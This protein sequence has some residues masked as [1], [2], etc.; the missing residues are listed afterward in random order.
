MLSHAVNAMKV[1]LDE[2]KLEQLQ[3]LYKQAHDL[4]YG[5]KIK[6]FS[7]GFDEKLSLIKHFVDNYESIALNQHHQ[8]I[9]V[10][11]SSA[12]SID[13]PATP[14]NEE[15]FGSVH[16][17]TELSKVM[18]EYI[19]KM[20][21]NNVFMT[22]LPA[23]KQITH[24]M[25]QF[26]M[27]ALEIMPC[28]GWSDTHMVSFLQVAAYVIQ[29]AREQDPWLSAEKLK[30]VIFAMSRIA[31]SQPTMR[32][33]IEEL[34][35]CLISPPQSE[36][37]AENFCHWRELYKST[38]ITSSLNF[39]S[40]E[41]REKYIEL[42]IYNSSYYA[43]QLIDQLDCKSI[44][45]AI[46][47]IF[48]IATEFQP[49]HFI[50][51]AIEHKAPNE[52]FKYFNIDFLINHI[53]TKP[54]MYEI[55]DDEFAK[56]LAT[57]LDDLKRRVSDEEEL[58]ISK[59]IIE[60]LT[61]H[62]KPTQRVLP[63]THIVLK[64]SYL[65][66]A[67]MVKQRQLQ[68]KANKSAADHYD[69]ILIA[70]AKNHLL[71]PEDVTKE[72]NAYRLRWASS[73]EINIYMDFLN[74]KFHDLESRK[75]V[76]LSFKTLMKLN[77]AT[78][79]ERSCVISCVG[80]ISELQSQLQNNKTDKDQLFAWT[81]EAFALIILLYK[82]V[83]VEAFKKFCATY[84][85]LNDYILNFGIY[86]VL[87]ASYVLF[88]DTRDKIALNSLYPDVMF[89]FMKEIGASNDQLQVFLN[90]VI[91]N[92]PELGKWSNIFYFL[93]NTIEKY[94]LI[95]GEQLTKM[96]GTIYQ[97]LYDHPFETFNTAVVSASFIVKLSQLIKNLQYQ[98]D[99]N[100]LSTEVNGQMDWIIKRFLIFS[101]SLK[102]QI[103]NNPSNEDEKLDRIFALKQLLKHAL[104]IEKSVYKKDALRALVRLNEKIQ[105]SYTPE[106]LKNLNSPGEPEF[107]MLYGA[108]H[109]AQRTKGQVEYELYNLPSNET[110]DIAK[111][112]YGNEVMPFP[113]S[114]TFFQSEYGLL[115]GFLGH[116]IASKSYDPLPDTFKKELSQDAFCMISKICTA[117]SQQIFLEGIKWVIT[118]NQALPKRPL[119]LLIEQLAA[120]RGFVQLD[121]DVPIYNVFDAVNLLR[122][123]GDV[124]SQYE[125][126]KYIFDHHV[127]Y[128]VHLNITGLHPIS[129]M[130]VKSY[131]AHSIESA[132]WQQFYLSEPIENKLL[133]R[134]LNLFKSLSKEL[135][136]AINMH[137]QK[138]PNS[139]QGLYGLSMDSTVLNVSDLWGNK[140]LIVRLRDF[141]KEHRSMLNDKKLNTASEQPDDIWLFCNLYQKKQSGQM[142]PDVLMNLIDFSD[143]IHEYNTVLSTIVRSLSCQLTLAK[144]HYI[145]D[146]KKYEYDD[147]LCQLGEL[148]DHI[149][150]MVRSNDN[151]DNANK[152]LIINLL[153]QKID[154][155]LLKSTYIS[156]TG[157]I[158]TTLD[159]VYQKS[160]SLKALQENMTFSFLSQGLHFING[161]YEFESANG[162]ILQEVVAQQA[163]N[164][165]PYFQEFFKMVALSKKTGTEIVNNFNAFPD[166][167]FL[168]EKND[169][170][171]RIG[172]YRQKV[173]SGE[174]CLISALSYLMQQHQ[175]FESIDQLWFDLGLSRMGNA[176]Q[177]RFGTFP[178]DFDL[179]EI[180]EENLDS[181]LNKSRNSDRHLI[182]LP[183]LMRY[184]YY[185][186]KKLAN[187]DLLDYCRRL[188]IEYLSLVTEHSEL[189]ASDRFELSINDSLICIKI[190][191]A[192]L[193]SI[194]IDNKVM[195]AIDRCGQEIAK[196]IQLA[197]DSI[198]KRLKRISPRLVC[199]FSKYKANVSLAD[200]VIS[201]VDYLDYDSVSALLSSDQFSRTSIQQ[202]M[203]QYEP[204]ALLEMTLGDSRAIA[205]ML[206]MYQYAESKSLLLTLGG[207]VAIFCHLG[208]TISEDAGGYFHL[209]VSKDQIKDW[210]DF[211]QA[212]G[213]SCKQRNE[214]LIVICSNS[215]RLSVS[216]IKTSLDSLAEIERPIDFSKPVILSNNINHQKY[217]LKQSIDERFCGL[218]R[219]S[220]ELIYFL[221]ISNALELS[222]DDL[223][224]KHANKVEKWM[225]V[226]FSL[227]KHYGIHNYAMN[228]FTVIELVKN[229]FPY[230]TIDKRVEDY[231]EQFKIDHTNLLGIS[232]RIIADVYTSGQSIDCS[233]L[234]QYLQTVVNY[235]ENLRDF[236]GQVQNLA[237][238]PVLAR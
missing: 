225:E 103:N 201:S 220:H 214:K 203:S 78:T 133:Q 7:Q 19:K 108:G 107:E 189:L 21:E 51:T 88:K 137:A 179:L 221:K 10:I 4:D 166:I 170:E 60:L 132:D 98:I 3:E 134:F 90:E 2:K 18:S 227:I 131:G 61:Y 167:E 77:S 68:G 146:N 188:M 64:N 165:E 37:F 100:K 101:L 40:D 17:V 93:K 12:R 5:D 114:I 59:K 176:I 87:N 158:A 56:E 198:Q 204:K 125:A 57:A 38:I 145:F 42:L 230:L 89:Q 130:V 210:R 115:F 192:A 66:S 104:S 174:Q 73:A 177:S 43:K 30:L 234:Q 82:L 206:E 159:F 219:M 39:N 127:E 150:Q 118:K 171:V 32:G 193:E 155:A 34:V 211:F 8:L 35:L 195:D 62:D 191:G 208:K 92:A 31:T 29:H 119:I 49:Y 72:Q 139:K 95:S 121:Y 194:A 99:A 215:L 222:I 74:K 97:R 144:D 69:L 231:L 129:K 45:N 22:I 196:R 91:D 110:I 143:S 168:I 96:V 113:N 164:D 229:T 84:R 209:Y 175:H 207:E 13:V 79:R 71:C 200:Y 58:F 149:I 53:D 24:E 52:S 212:K 180:S 185:C 163:I 161:K 184:T 41:G 50:K 138:R 15:L 63:N 70:R 205:L 236:V 81:S 135:S 106:Q 217:L 147:K 148:F 120:A 160:W 153:N 181:T 14:S 237:A 238:M 226:H 223:I 183:A 136:A 76:Y 216:E 16:K 85:D 157:K 116:T 232:Y 122:N 190:N 94:P 162:D 218:S 102:W 105:D 23:D 27:K 65:C 20:L 199:K 197:K 36:E 169:L 28:F 26:F 151:I 44:K 140:K 117:R 126:L 186:G 187:H 235:D 109:I 152:L 86:R 123:S 47:T 182:H 111:Y 9:M 172:K 173:D 142:M 128:M 54:T 224:L 154:R 75:M 25:H 46:E 1:G 124:A 202:I 11:A 178:K 80:M 48:C 6:S 233:L 141:V 55:I 156:I 112:L 213:L 228:K 67:G 83:G 33:D